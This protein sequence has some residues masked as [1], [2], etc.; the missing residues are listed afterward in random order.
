M[1]Q[2]KCRGC[3]ERRVGCHAECEKYA[4]FMAENQKALDKRDEDREYYDFVKV[5]SGRNS[6]KYRKKRKGG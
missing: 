1:I 3:T 6:K 4:E 2:S 5:R